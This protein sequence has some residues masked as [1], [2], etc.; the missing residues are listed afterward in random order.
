MLGDAD[1]RHKVGASDDRD[2]GPSAIARGRVSRPDRL[3]RLARRRRAHRRRV[4]TGGPVAA[5]SPMLSAA[6][7]VSGSLRAHAADYR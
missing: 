4:G 3:R 5:L 1:R 7:A 6:L 2:R